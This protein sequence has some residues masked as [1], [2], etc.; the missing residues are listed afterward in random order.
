MTETR[1]LEAYEQRLQSQ[2]D[3]HIG[4]YLIELNKSFVAA[5]LTHLQAHGFESVTSHH[6]HIIAQ[7]DVAGTSIA[8]VLKRSGVTKQSLSNIL[9]ILESNGLVQQVASE[10]DGRG[11]QVRFPGKGMSLLQVGLD[12]VH[13]VE[14]QYATAIGEKRFEVLK[15]ALGELH[16]A[17]THR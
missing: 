10:D 15:Q 12:A 2:R 3:H 7:I 8:D 16:N 1:Q 4:R 13:A 14:R 17:V 5:T 11:K 6:I 9:K